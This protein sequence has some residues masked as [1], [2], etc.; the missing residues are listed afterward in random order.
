MSTDVTVVDRINYRINDSQRDVED[1]LEEHLHRWGCSPG[2]LAHTRTMR[3]YFRVP[4][5]LTVW[6]EEPTRTRV[7]R[8]L[9]LHLLAMKLLDD[10]VDDDSGLATRDLLQAFFLAQNAAVAGLCGSS[11]DPAALAARLD[12]DLEAVTLG[13]VATKAEP[14]V[15][16]AGWLRHAESYGGRFLALYGS[17]ACDA[18]NRLD[19]DVAARGFGRAF[20][21]VITMA[22][23]L[24]D[25]D[26]HGE[27]TG[28]LR[29]LVVSG[30]VDV[31]DAVAAVRRLADEACDAVRTGEPA[32]DLR[33]LV[34]SYADE[35]VAGLRAAAG[36]GA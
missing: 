8:L 25:Y 16:L 3:L 30:A 28:N 13:Q 32:E 12:A 9:G 19:M 33:P 11:A 20:G 22:D 14:A 24:R 29:H 36:A 4:H 7:A 6:L 15:D 2:L 27:R 21:L 5:M 26:R 31:D 35:V 17:L 34:G 18:G 1:H 23:D 10:V